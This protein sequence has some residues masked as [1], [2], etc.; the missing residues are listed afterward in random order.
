MPISNAKS[1]ALLFG[2]M[3]MTIKSI[4]SI[5]NGLFGINT[6]VGSFFYVNM[7]NSYFIMGSCV[8]SVSGERIVVE[9]R[10]LLR[11]SEQHYYS[12]YCYLGFTI[13]YLSPKQTLLLP[14][15]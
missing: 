3:F 14:S 13:I 2:R 9:L 8:V 11:L 7:R 10:V 4:F 6:A 12:C 1:V 15:T 5:L